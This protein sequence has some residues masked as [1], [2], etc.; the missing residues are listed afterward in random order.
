MKVC[1]VCSFNCEDD[2]E[3][4][5]VCGAD[6]TE[7]PQPENDREDSEDAVLKEPVLLATFEDIVSGEIFRD[8]LKD[9][10]II[11]ACDNAMGEGTMQVT[12]GGGFIS[13]NIYV[14]K[15]DFD[16]ADALYN[17]FLESDES[18][19]DDTVYLETPDGE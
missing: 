5:P 11:Y 14:E 6:L 9:N 2:A 13:D 12:F 7:E 1:H 15:S 4:C 17:E 10:G 16:K 19:F 8:I 18:F 3:L